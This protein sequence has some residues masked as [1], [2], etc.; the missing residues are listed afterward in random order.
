MYFSKVPLKRKS[1]ENS[2]TCLFC[3]DLNNIVQNP[4]AESYLTVQK[5]TFRRRDDVK[6]KFD[7]MYDSNAIKQTF[8]WH[9]TCFSNYVSEEK[10]RR[11]EIELQKT[12]NETVT[13]P[14][15]PTSTEFCERSQMKL[16]SL[17]DD[18]NNKVES[19]CIICNQFKK[20]GVTSTYVISNRDC[21]EKLMIS[22][23]SKMDHIF[24]KISIYDN[25]ESILAQELRYHDMS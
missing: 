2:L 11:R 15:T 25:V 8:S 7:S 4:K 12:I 14:T 9:R 16:R 23:R 6:S 21:A 18:I 5:A 10:I 24:T 22:A 19:K 13:S 17:R 1:L 20:D 3:N